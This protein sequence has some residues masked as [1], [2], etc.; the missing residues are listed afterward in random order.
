MWLKVLPEIVPPGE[1]E[2]ATPRSLPVKVLP[3]SCW[4][5]T[6]WSVSAVMAL[7]NV[8]FLNRSL[9]KPK[10]L[11]TTGL[12]VNLLPVI[13]VNPSMLN[14]SDV[15]VKVSSVNVGPGDCW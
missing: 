7:L 15:F 8:S 14:V 10:P 4:L 1:S 3:T 12:S 2:I 11:L 5:G 13:V 9:P 6:S